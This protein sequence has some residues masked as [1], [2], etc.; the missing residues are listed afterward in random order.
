[1]TP[2]PT[3]TPDGRKIVTSFDPKPIPRRDFDWC[4]V[5]DDYDGAQDSRC[6]IGYGRTED[7]AIADLISLLDEAAA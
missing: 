2:R 4:A 1:M 3:H 6:P 5:T 7:A